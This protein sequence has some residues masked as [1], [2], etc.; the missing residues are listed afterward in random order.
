MTRLV[1][2]RD[3]ESVDLLDTILYS[4][5]GWERGT[6][7]AEP[8]SMLAFLTL[9][10]C[11]AIRVMMRP[12]CF[13]HD[14]QDEPKIMT[15]YQKLVPR[16]R[17]KPYGERELIRLN[18]LWQLRHLGMPDYQEYIQYRDGACEALCGNIFPAALLTHLAN[19]EHLRRFYIFPYPYW[20]ES[21]TAVYYCLKFTS[22]AVMGAKQYQE[23]V[24]D[25]IRAASITDSVF[26]DGHSMR[27]KAALP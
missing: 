10:E 14:I 27:E 21:H 1:F 23:S 7:M 4:Y 24:W 13:R 15:V 8:K 12:Y 18:A 17:W 11:Q 19:H 3:V 16:T 2:N 26:T 25:T 20:N 9:L 5:S 6:V 22:R